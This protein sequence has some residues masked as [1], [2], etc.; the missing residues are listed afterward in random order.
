MIPQIDKETNIQ[1]LPPELLEETHK[2]DYAPKPTF[3]QWNLLDEV[4]HVDDNHIAKKLKRS[5]DLGLPE[6]KFSSTPPYHNLPSSTPYSLNKPLPTYYRKTSSSIILSKK[7]NLKP[8]LL[9]DIPPKSLLIQN[10]SSSSPIDVLRHQIQK[11]DHVINQLKSKI[12]NLEKSLAVKD[13]VLLK[14]NK[15]IQELQKYKQ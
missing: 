12:A 14:K 7:P 4:V 15:I 8:P 9:A 3:N 6:P 2:I 5:K 10:N 11:Q 13:E 1:I